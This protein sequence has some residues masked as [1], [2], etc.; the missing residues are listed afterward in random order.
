[1]MPF[2]SAQWTQMGSDI[3][4]QIANDESGFAID[5]NALGDLLVIGANK[6]DV[7]GLNSGKVRVY[8]FDSEQWMQHG[9]DID[10][11]NAMD[12]FGY[13]VKLSADGM[14][15]AI[16]APNT[17]TGPNAPP[18]YVRVFEWSTDAW[19]QRG[20]DIALNVNSDGFGAALDLSADG[21]SLII[22]AQLHPIDGQWAVGRAQVFEWNGQNYVTLGDGIIGSNASGSGYT[23]RAVNINETGTIISISDVIDSHG[24]V[25]IFDRAGETW[26]PKDTLIGDEISFGRMTAMDAGGNTIATFN[27]TLSMSQGSV[28]VFGFDGN[29]YAPKGDIIVGDQGSDFLG[30]DAL[31]LSSDG[32]TLA[33][34]AEATGVGFARMMQFNGNSWQALGNPIVGDSLSIQH[35]RSTALSAD[36]SRVAIGTPFNTGALPNAGIVHVWENQLPTPIYVTQQSNT[37]ILFP[38]PVSSEVNL[39]VPNQ[40]LGVPYTV[41]DVTGRQV[42]SG[43]LL[44]VNESVSLA[45]LSKGVY[46]FRCTRMT[47]RIVKQ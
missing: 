45:S 23:G 22:G 43:T 38:N 5:L 36:G 15:L 46:V 16:G 24:R 9:N 44:E 14:I 42:I 21:N 26:V 8:R 4:G 19:V 33:V 13:A 29:T 30:F 39:I 12:E 32:N 41:H 35:G 47:Q 2:A 17:Y 1:M 18:G 25:R 28:R 27:G 6:S 3:M 40:L 37:S 11:S 34:G 7:N 20:A 31:S 10:G